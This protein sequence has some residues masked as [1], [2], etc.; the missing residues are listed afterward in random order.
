MLFLIPSFTLPSKLYHLHSSINN[1]HVNFHM[2][3]SNFL[4][5]L[6]INSPQTILSK[7]KIEYVMTVGARLTCLSSNSEHENISLGEVSA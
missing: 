6:I 5:I 1:V 7:L 3:Q 4:V 2:H